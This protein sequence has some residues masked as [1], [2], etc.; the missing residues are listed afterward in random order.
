MHPYE[1]QYAQPPPGDIPREIV[2]YR[3]LVLPPMLHQLPEHY[4]DLLPRYNGKQKMTAQQYLD[5]FHDYMESLNV[6]FED[7]YMRLF[8]QSLVGKP[9]KNFQSLDIASIHS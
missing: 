5:S 6:Q 8:I 7:V 1:Q 3:P 4:L 2:Q 9:M